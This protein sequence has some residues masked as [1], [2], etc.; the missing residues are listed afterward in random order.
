MKS[1]L[2]LSALGICI[3]TGC[4]TGPEDGR[5]LESAA[6]T[7]TIKGY[8]D[9]ASTRVV[10]EEERDGQWYAVTEVVSQSRNAPISKE[11]FEFRFEDAVVSSWAKAEAGSDHP[12]QANLRIVVP[13]G[14]QV[15]QLYTFDLG[16]LRCLRQGIRSADPIAAG[17]R[18]ATGQTLRLFAKRRTKKAGPEL[19]RAP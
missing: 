18:C 19:A 16:G 3:S 14:R 5:V 8:A 13:D 17:R 15:R 2:A 7:V 6:Q 9:K 10:L 11:L 12:L 4:V 1:T